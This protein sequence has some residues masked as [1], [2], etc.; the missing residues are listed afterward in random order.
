MEWVKSSFSVPQGNC[1]EV[2]VLPDG[3][4]AVRDSKDNGSGPVLGFTREEWAAFT[5]GVKAGEFG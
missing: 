5:D 3:G 1:V 2:G 4:M